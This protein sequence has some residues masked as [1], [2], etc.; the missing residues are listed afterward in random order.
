MKLS[1]FSVERPV[2]TTMVMCI[3][4]ILGGVA[5]SRLPIDLM[6]DVTYPVLSVVTE[7]SNAG[8]EEVEDLITKPIEQA[9]AAVPGVEAVSSTSSE[10]TSVVR[11]SF[12]WGTDLDSAANDIRDRLERTFSSL[13]DGANRPTLRKFDLAQFPILIL[14]VTSK[15]DPIEVRRIIDEQINYRFERIPG[16]AAVDSWGGLEREIQV[17][18]NP[19][20]IKA[21]GLSFREIINGIKNQNVTIPTGTI[22]RGNYD[23]VV[24]TSGEFADLDELRR[25]VVATRG[26]SPIQ[27]KDIAIVEAATK[28]LTRIVRINGQPG[29]RMAIR[30]Q[31]QANTVEVAE[32][33]LKELEE[34]NRD[35]PQLTIIPLIDSS[36][37]IKRSITS[38]STVAGYGG[39]FAIVILLLF[40]RN[41][42]S[43][44]I[45]AT[46]IPI[47]IIGTFV[48][49]YFSG[50]TLNLMTL[51]GLAIG[52]GMIVDNSI[53]VLENIFRLRVKGESQTEAAIS[54]SEEV[55]SAIIAS[56]LTTLVIFLPL[57]FVKGIAGI[58]FKQLAFVISFALLCSLLVALMLIPMLASRFIRVSASDGPSTMGSFFSRFSNG[59]EYLLN[60]A[61]T[62]RK[63]TILAV[64]IVLG[65]SLGLLPF[66][67]VEYM[68]KAD[69][70]EVRVSVTMD[71]GTSLDVLTEKF[72]L[73]EAIVRDSVPEMKSM[74]ARLGASNWRAGGSHS[75]SL[76]IALVPATERNRSDEAI[77]GTLRQK[78][79]NI[80][81]MQIYTRAGQGLFIFRIVFGGAQESIQIDIRGYDLKTSQLLAAEIKKRVETVDGVTD[82]R[83]SLEAG[84]PE[85]RIDVDR[86]R[87]A[88]LKVNVSDIATTLQTILSGTSSGKYRVGGKE[89]DIIVK[90]KDA[91]ILDISELLD[92]TVINADGKPVVMKNVVKV[93]SHSAPVQISRKDQERVVTLS[94]NIADRDMNSILTD[95]RERMTDMVVPR[96]FSIVYSGDYEEQQKAFRELLIGI[97]LAIVLV[98]ML[99][100][101]LYESVRDPFIVIFSVPMA[102]VGV[103]IMLFLTNTT[104][105]VQS[106]I[107]CIML[108]GIVVNNAILLVD[109]INLLRERD[110]L[111]VN[112]AIIEAG[113]RR[114]RPILMTA[115]T[116]MLGMAPL[117]LGMME[118]G[119]TQAPLARVVIGGLASS[120]LI[121]LII[122]PVIYSFAEQWFPK[123]ATAKD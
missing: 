118:G 25:T 5:L 87:A 120:A 27:L 64:M 111:P 52:V 61:L 82:V 77:A 35:V 17:K 53:V 7:Y 110:G 73:V 18:V 11:I 72:N 75:G 37:Y 12:I 106:Y 96:E 42:R 95:I 81:G 121:T 29:I 19:T 47:S 62:Y 100:A 92:L 123:K 13:P 15:L 67:G 65:L 85:E 45:I 48:F 1:R 107:G 34:I 31:S 46:A 109:Y 66:I 74:V 97:I 114:L 86:D 36:D 40:L 56:T 69:E 93:R 23:L 57:I 59:Y 90:V 30:K 51:G 3:V 24:S 98:Y 8:P 32:L 115:L 108:A 119:E 55:T 26:G 117:S 101:S 103:L 60:Q 21:L 54:G 50:F 76:Q 89:Y 112:E 41:L 16:V 33:A 80:P 58:M 99:L 79:S 20:K 88:D 78:L 4:M 14:G 9:I 2:F 84:R 63:T 102:I 91:E 116:T 105:N 70:N 122:V 38:V 10:G 44:A 71:V 104:F 28:K 6:P 39:L 22:K 94:V 68:P 49:V 113:R 83:L 43:T